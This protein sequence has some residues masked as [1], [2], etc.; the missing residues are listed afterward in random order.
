MAEMAMLT[1]KFRHSGAIEV[2]LVTI[3]RYT[4][5]HRLHYT[6]AQDMV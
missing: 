3:M 2:D 5:I 6:K 1:F 4:K